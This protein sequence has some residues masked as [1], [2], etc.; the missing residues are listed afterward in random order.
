MNG[1][2]SSIR[3]PGLYD[4]GYVQRIYAD[5]EEDLIALGRVG[6]RTICSLDIFLYVITMQAIYIWYILSFSQG[7]PHIFPAT[8]SPPVACL[9]SRTQMIG[10]VP[11][12]K[13]WLKLM[14]WSRGPPVGR[15]RNLGEVV[16]V[17]WTCCRL[18]WNRNRWP[19]NQKHIT[20][21]AY[22]LRRW[23]FWSLLG[24]SRVSLVD[25]NRLL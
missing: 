14:W 11:D 9:I 18:D 7:S 13:V 5:Q 16:E 24:W 21:L 8:S 25:R 12:W 6:Y 15:K 20:C 19:T 23:W 1:A 2:P 4:G 3:S 17:K 10:N 22:L